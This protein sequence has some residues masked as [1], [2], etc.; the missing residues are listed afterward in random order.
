MRAIGFWILDN[1]PLGRFA[2]YF[3]GWLLGSKPEPVKKE[4]MQAVIVEKGDICFFCGKEMEVRST[5]GNKVGL[6][7]PNDCCFYYVD[8]ETGKLAQE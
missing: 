4:T 8:I 2:P 6:W 3:L 7:C 5:D 1:I